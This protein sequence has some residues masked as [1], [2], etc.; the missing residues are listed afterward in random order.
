MVKT[1]RG[2]TAVQ[3]VWSFLRGSRDT[4]ARSHDALRN[5]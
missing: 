4:A 5:E 1:K 2:V 3:V